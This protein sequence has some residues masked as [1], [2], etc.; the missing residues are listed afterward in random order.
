MPTRLLLEIGN[1]TVKLATVG[2]NGGIAV[3]RY[4]NLE[5]LLRRIEAADLPIVAAV[6]GGALG[7]DILER[8]DDAAEITLVER[9]AYGWLVADSYDTPETLGLDRILNLAGLD[10]DAVVI[11]CGTAI[12]IDALSNA[13]CWWG[14]ILPGFTTS[15]DG[16]HSR[17]PQLPLVSTRFPV[18]LPARDSVTSVANGIMLGVAIGAQGIAAELGAVAFEGDIPRVVLTGGEAEVMRKFWRE[19]LGVSVD[20]ALL[21]RG[22]LAGIDRSS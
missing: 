19:S 14:A 7:Q 21:F 18:S 9:S 5:A 22:M 11:S 2:D 1:S 8:L 15:A 4:S 3:E 16:L 13:R 12:T 17:I 20:D 10:G 6:T